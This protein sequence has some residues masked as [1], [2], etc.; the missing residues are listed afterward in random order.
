[1][2]LIYWTYSILIS[3]LLL[4]NYFVKRF[5]QL[6]V[7]NKVWTYYSYFLTLVFMLGFYILQKLHNYIYFYLT[8]IITFIIS[9]TFITI[10]GHL[11]NNIAYN[12]LIWFLVTISTLTYMG[13]IQ[14]VYHLYYN[15]YNDPEIG[16]TGI[17]G[18]PGLIGY[19][20]NSS[21]SN[22]DVCQEQLN[23]ETNNLLHKMNTADTT[24]KEFKNLFLKEKYKKMCTV[25]NQVKI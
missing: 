5:N 22:F 25:F 23:N 2:K 21:M 24:N 15:N 11:G 14:S 1:M 13:L 12:F 17:Q 20:A 16:L 9:I 10:F 18:E 6:N 3:F 19:D 8:M 7:I 4:L